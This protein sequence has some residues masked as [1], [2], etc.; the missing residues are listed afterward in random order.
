MN[1]TFK[2]LAQAPSCL[3]FFKKLFCVSAVVLLVGLLMKSQVMIFVGGATLAVAAIFFAP[4]L[5]YRRKLKDS[6]DNDFNS[7]S[8]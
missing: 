1:D 2:K 6:A 4:I 3:A 8:Q 5:V 7:D